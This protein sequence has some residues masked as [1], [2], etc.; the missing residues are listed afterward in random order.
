MIEIKNLSFGYKRRHKIFSDFSMQLGEGLVCGLL[1]K[2]GTGKSTLLHLMS[3][4]L[5]PSAGC[6]EYNGVNTRDRKVSTLADMFLVPEEFML[7]DMKLDDFVRINSVFYPKFSGEA[8]KH[9]SEMFELDGSMR[10]NSLSMG[11]KKKAFLSFAFATNVNL[12]LMDEPTNGLDIPSKGQFRKVLSSFM[13][14]CKS[15]VISTHQVNDVDNLLD[16]V[17]ILE[18]NRV[19]LNETLA[20][21]ASRVS[22]VSCD[23]V[24]DNAFYS[25]PS[26]LGHFAVVPCTDGHETTINTE[27]LFNAVISSPALADYIR[28]ED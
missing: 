3:G 14:D 11:Q 7:P 24:P 16:H 27:L 8:M 5:T 13:D 28:K 6:V 22:V 20:R 26:P 2:N 21:I 19:L 1:G 4:L 25:Q 15:V 12:L 17:L 9:N 18:N 23:H 10:L